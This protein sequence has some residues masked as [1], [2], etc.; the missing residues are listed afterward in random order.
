MAFRALS[1]ERMTCSTANLPRLLKH[2]SQRSNLTRFIR[3]SIYGYLN[4]QDIIVKISTLNKFERNELETSF[5]VRENKTFT[6]ELRTSAKNGGSVRWSMLSNIHQE[7]GVINEIPPRLVDFIPRLVTEL[8]I[9]VDLQ[10]CNHL[11]ELVTTLK[12]LPLRFDNKCVSLAITDIP[13]QTK[14]DAITVD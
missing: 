11:G 10:L 9:F 5:F 12:Q 8:K 4:L 1:I 6:M 7:M 14:D 13:N 3:L 2:G